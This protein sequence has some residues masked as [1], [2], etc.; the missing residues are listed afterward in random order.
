MVQISPEDHPRRHQRGLPED[1]DSGD[2]QEEAPRPLERAGGDAAR[3][4]LAHRKK[5][6]KAVRQDCRAA[7]FASG[8]EVRFLEHRNKVHSNSTKV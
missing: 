4:E 7:F 6:H 5:E 3:R 2:A 8:N 1:P